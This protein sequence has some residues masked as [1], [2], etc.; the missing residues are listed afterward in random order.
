MKYLVK[1]RTV[2]IWEHW[3]EVEANSADEANDIITEGTGNCMQV[4]DYNENFLYTDEE[5]VEEVKP[6]ADEH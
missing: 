1:T 5:E 6:L 4:K 3:Y 2:E